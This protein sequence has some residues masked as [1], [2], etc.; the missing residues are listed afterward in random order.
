MPL[1]TFKTSISN[2]MLNMFNVNEF[3]VNCLN[4]RT[5]L[6]FG[7]IFEEVSVDVNNDG[8]PIILDNP[9][10]YT[11]S[12]NDIEQNDLLTIDGINYYVSKKPKDGINGTEVYLKYA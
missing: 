12:I 2:D 10:I 3:A 9:V 11:Q 4:T 5:G 1:L 8:M 6:T 7:V